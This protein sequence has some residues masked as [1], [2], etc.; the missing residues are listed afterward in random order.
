MSAVDVT[1]DHAYIIKQNGY[2]RKRLAA[3]LTVS[4]VARAETLIQQRIGTADISVQFDPSTAALTLRGV[5]SSYYQKQLAQE[6]VRHLGQ[7]SHVMN[8]LEVCELATRPH[9]GGDRE[10]TATPETDGESS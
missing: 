6:S 2:W 8:G 10:T 4:V 3:P 9:V 5:V 7:V 1:T